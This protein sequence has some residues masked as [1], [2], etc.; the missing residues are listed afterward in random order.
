MRDIQKPGRSVVMGKQGMVATSQPMATQAGL[1]VLHRGGNAMDAAIAAGSVLCVTEPQSTGIG[2]DCFIL[3]HEAASGKLHGLNGSGRAPGGATLSAYQ[4]LGYEQVPI[5]GIHAVTV[6]GAIDGWAQAVQRFGTMS[7]GDLLQ[8]AI[9]YAEEGYAVSPVVAHF[10]ARNADDLSQFEDSARVLLA[11]GRAP[12]AGCVH[13]QPDL[14]RSLRRIAEEGRDAFYLGPIAEEICRVSE[15]QGG[16]FQM[17]DFAAHRSEWVAPLYSRYRD[18]RLVE[19][20]PNGQGITAQM[21]L[22]ILE[23]LDIAAMPRLG[24][25]HLHAFSEAFKLAMA[26]RD[27]FVSDPAFHPLPVEQLLSDD[28]AAGQRARLDAGRALDHPVASGFPDH[29]DTVYLSVVDKDRNACSYINSLFWNFGS[30]LVAGN[31]GITLQNRG[32]GFVL[33][34]GHF[35]CI[36]P[37]KR[38]LHTIIPAMAYRDSGEMLCYGVMGG[39]YQAMGHAYVLSNLVDYG[40]D[41]QEAIDAPRFLPYEGQLSLERGIAPA[42]MEELAALGHQVVLAEEPLG[43]GQAIWTDFRTGV[44]H[45]ASDPRKDGCALGY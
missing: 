24:S 8:P 1:E 40:L 17:E 9:G 13:R 34:K 3:Y 28:F 27:R 26:E 37:G 22:N 35:N 4:A 2:G 21:T 5:R 38:P 39:Q 18:M 19:I 20:P 29:R 14:A 36:A 33:Q 15:E 42:V 43:G 6:P 7:L 41:L 45:A 32:S 31:T 12:V 25:A 44:L 10:W 16:F 30:A 23:G 11:D